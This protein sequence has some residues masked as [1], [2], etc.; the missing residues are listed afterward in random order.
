MGLFEFNKRNI[1]LENVINARF[2]SILLIF[3][4]NT[5]LC[6]MQLRRHKSSL[7]MMFVNEIN[8]TFF[9]INV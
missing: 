9:Y 5:L 8:N 2:D 7:I 6:K 1:N 3:A 4:V